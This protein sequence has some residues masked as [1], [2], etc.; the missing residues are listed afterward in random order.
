MNA[1]PHRPAPAGPDDSGRFPSL[2]GTSL[3]A[4]WYLPEGPPRATALVLHG[5]GEHGGRY[6]ETARILTGAGLSVLVYDT[7]GHGRSDGR[8]GYVRGFRDYLADLRGALDELA[9]RNQAAF[10]GDP[11]LPL[12]LVGHSN[13]ALVALRALT[14]P[15]QMPAGLV[16]AVLSSPFL[17]LSTPVPK[18]KQALG[19][20]AGRYAPRLTMQSE[21]RLEALTHDPDKLAARRADPLCHD[22]VTARYF[23][24][25]ERAQRY[26]EQHIRELGVPTLWLVAGGDR[27]TDPEATRQV[28]SQLRAPSRYREFPQMH[29]EVFNELDRE[30]A[31]ELIRE[32][33]AQRANAATP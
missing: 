18:F 1:S 8:R 20:V 32:F 15:E 7:R 19:V 22:V 26:V 13:G 6:C 4:E 9:R 2:D 31:F 12:F 17:R 5:Y 21:I 33:V 16:G 25:A 23:T 3:H 14:D 29:H 27:V 28:H 10:A 30:Q 11:A 24:A